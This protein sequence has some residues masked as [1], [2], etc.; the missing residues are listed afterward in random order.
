MY[1]HFKDREKVTDRYDGFYR[2][3]VVNN[4]DPKKSGRIQI[5]V[6]PMFEGVDDRDLPW[7]IFAD[8]QM[9]GYSNVGGVNIPLVNSHV[10]LFF[11]NGDF[12]FPVYFA[13]APSIENNNPDIPTLSRKTDIEVTNINEARSTSVPTANGGA[14][15]EPVSAYAAVYP[16]NRVYRSEK[17]ILVELDDTDGKVRIHIYHPSGTREEIDNSGN[18]VEHVVATKTTV[19]AG[20]DNNEVKG[21]QNITVRS[22]HKLKIEGQGDVEI[23]GKRNI[24]V[25]GDSDLTVSGNVN[26]TA[27][28]INLN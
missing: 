19:I 24:V 23:T 1:N 27:T 18:K 22:N 25:G 9:G 8:P 12:R 3:I 6:Y 13:G 14:F 4:N 11:E 21:N 15:S 10:F 26:V 20:N 2:G 7:A 5:R 28:T 17:G 16:N